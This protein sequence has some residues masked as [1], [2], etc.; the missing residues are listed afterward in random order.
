MRF[1]YEV[2]NQ[3]LDD[4]VT[5]NVNRQSRREAALTGRAPVSC[6]SSKSAIASTGISALSSIMNASII[7]GETAAFSGP[8]HLHLMDPGAWFWSLNGATIA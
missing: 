3:Q 5:P 7:R 2:Q 6:S 4:I 1:T 8:G